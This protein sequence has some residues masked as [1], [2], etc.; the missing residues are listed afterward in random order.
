[1]TTELQ[2]RRSDFNDVSPRHWQTLFTRLPE[3]VAIYETIAYDRGLPVDYRIVDVNR[4]YEVITGIPREAALGKLASIV[5]SPDTLSSLEQFRDVV[6][7]GVARTLEV[8]NAFGNRSFA[9]TVVPLSEST[10]ATFFREKLELR[11]PINA[12][13]DSPNLT[14]VPTQVTSKHTLAATITEQHHA[15]VTLNESEKRFRTLFHLS[16]NPVAIATLDRWRVVE[17]NDAYAETIGSSRDALIADEAHC[18][19]LERPEVQRKVQAQLETFNRFDDIEFEYPLPN[20]SRRLFG[21]SGCLIQY[22][23]NPHVMVSAFDVTELREAER[24][25]ARSHEQLIRVSELAHIGHF[26]ANVDTGSV[27][28]SAELFRIF[29]HE[30]HSFV[31]TLE[32]LRGSVLPEESPR[33]NTISTGSTAT[34][35]AQRTEFRIRRPGGEIRHCLSYV[36]SND[37]SEGCPSHL[38]GLV[39]DLTEVKRAEEDRRI[40]EQQ[41]MQ[42][43][44]L[45]SLGG[46]AGGIAHDFNN[47][48]TSVLGNAD[49]ALSDLPPDSPVRVYLEDI[50]TVGHNAAHLCRQMLAY[51]GRGRF[52]VEPIKLNE[53]VSE[54]AH[55]LTVSAGRK[56]D[57]QY[58]LGDGLPAV[59]ADASQIRQLVIN[60]V[61]NAAEAIEE[62]GGAITLATDVVNCDETYFL[63]AVRDGSRHTPG[64]YLC[65]KVSDNGCGMTATTQERIFEPFF[66]TKFTGRGLGLAA[67]MGIVRGHGGAIKVQSTK[68]RGTTLNVLFP[69]YQQPACLTNVVP[70][71]STPWHGRGLVLLVD[72]EE[73]IRN[74]GRHLLIRAGFD[75]ITA[76]DGLEALEQFAQRRRE[77]RLVILDLTMP[78]LDGEAS[79]R[80]LRKLAPHVKVIMTSGYD[81]RDVRSRFDG[82]ELSG[83]VQ[84]PYNAATLLPLI[85]TTLGE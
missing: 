70:V 9:V 2:L 3:G 85:R 17:L 61:T 7:T 69:A 60:L 54:M 49:L 29:G 4:Q 1:M 15:E 55:L 36:E 18:W 83:F 48:L 53:L 80:Q 73:T 27:T 38:Y 25:A 75:V 33:P 46:L 34:R 30:P 26:S 82:L 8:R 59:M 39:Q 84:K 45:E 81:E 72:D 20:R 40:L 37:P 44:K 47:I 23:G 19:L 14:R 77:I 13:T 16:P 22:A 63:D 66:T 67:V 43:Q 62:Q 41:M 11:R 56:V 12:S 58:E 42:T 28:W 10:F 32:D 79:F 78:H 52:V 76:A 74:L 24:A 65:L 51:S 6:L 31:P 21:V 68:G 35:R 71:D 64:Q 5:Y 57:I 50:Q